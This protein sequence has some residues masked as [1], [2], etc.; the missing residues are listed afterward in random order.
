MPSSKGKYDPKITI[1]VE[2]DTKELGKLDQKIGEGFKGG[3]QKAKSFFDYVK[4]AGNAVF[5]GF[6]GKIGGMMASS[7]TRAFKKA[8]DEF[9]KLD[10]TIRKTMG[11]LSEQEIKK[12]GGIDGLK[13]IAKELSNQFGTDSSLISQN[14]FDAISLGAE[15]SEAAIKGILT[16]A[17]K[18]GKAADVESNTLVQ[19]IQG[20]TNT[21]TEFAGNAASVGDTMY[22]AMKRGAGELSDYSNGMKKVASTANVANIGMNQLAALGSSLSTTTKNVNSAFTQVERTITS[23][24]KPSGKAVKMIDQLN[25]KTGA[26]IQLGADAL[27]DK[28]LV[29]YLNEIKTAAESS[30]MKWGDVVGQIFSNVNAMKGAISLTSDSMVNTFETTFN[31]MNEAALNSGEVIEEAFG[32]MADSPKMTLDKLKQRLQN[33]FVGVIE[34]LFPLFEQLIPTIEKLLPVISN[35][36]KA[37]AGI[38]S[39]APVKFFIDALGGVSEVLARAFAPVE[40]AKGKFD[41]L[42][43]SIQKNI[44][45]VKGL[46]GIEFNKAIVEN[47]EIL[48]KKIDEVNAVAPELA[49]KMRLIAD[50]SLESSEKVQL[51]N[52]ELERFREIT[53]ATTG[54]EKGEAIKEFSRATQD[55]VFNYN[56]VI[57]KIK[58][59]EG[60]IGSLNDKQK[61]ELMEYRKKAEQIRNQF[62]VDSQKLVEMGIGKEAIEKNLK[63]IQGRMHGI[64][65]KSIFVNP[66]DKA[67]ENTYILN[68]SIE[69]LYGTIGIAEQKLKDETTDVMSGYLNLIKESNGLKEID[70]SLTSDSIVALAEINSM[71]ETQTAELAH[72]LQLKQE[73]LLLDLEILKAQQSEM[74]P[75]GV[76]YVETGEKIAETER[77]INLINTALESIPK[78]LDIGVNVEWL[79]AE[80]NLSDLK[81]S[82]TKLQESRKKFSEMPFVSQST[83]DKLDSA[84][85]ETRNKIVDASYEIAAMDVKITPEID[86][87]SLEAESE[88]VRN[89][90]DTVLQ[91]KSA[92]IG[93]TEDN[94]AMI[95]ATYQYHLDRI[96]QMSFDSE[97]EKNAQLLAL[98]QQKNEAIQS[99]FFV[100]GEQQARVDNLLTQINQI[101][102]SGAGDRQRIQLEAILQQEQAR[103]DIMKAQSAE[104]ARQLET[105]RQQKLMELIALEEERRAK[106]A[107]PIDDEEIIKIERAFEAQRKV[108]DGEIQLLDSTISGLDNTTKMQENLVNNINNSISNINTKQAEIRKQ[109]EEDRRQ[110]EKEREETEREAERERE[111]RQ[112]QLEREREEREREIER[113]REEAERKREEERRKYEEEKKQRQADAL[114]YIDRAYETDNELLAKFQDTMSEFNAIFSAEFLDEKT[115]AD[116]IKALEKNKKEIVESFVEDSLSEME[117]LQIID[118]ETAKLGFDMLREYEK[119]VM[120]LTA[121]MGEDIPKEMVETLR[122]AGVELLDQLKNKLE[123]A[124][125][126]QQ[127]E[128][129]ITYG[130]DQY[131]WLK[132]AKE[133]QK[134]LGEFEE[135]LKNFDVITDELIG[136][137]EK[138]KQDLD[139]EWLSI[140][141]ISSTAAME[142]IQDLLLDVEQAIKD[143]RDPEV[144]EQLVLLKESIENNNNLDQFQELLAAFEVI[145][146]ESGWG[147]TS[148]RSIENQIQTLVSILDYDISRRY[149][150]EDIGVQLE[151]LVNENGELHQAIMEIWDGLGDE[152]QKSYLKIED[153]YGAIQSFYETYKDEY[154]F[155]DIGDV[156]D[157]MDDLWDTVKQYQEDTNKDLKTAI[158]NTNTFIDEFYELQKAPI[159]AGKQEI[160]EQIPAIEELIKGGV[161]ATIVFKD[162]QAEFAKILDEMRLNGE[163][164]LDILKKQSEQQIE[165]IMQKQKAIVQGI[166]NIELEHELIKLRL[167]QKQIL[168]DIAEKEMELA[169]L[170][171]EYLYSTEYELLDIQKEY[172][173]S[174]LEQIELQNEVEKNQILMEVMTRKHTEEELQAAYEKMAII[175]EEFETSEE[176]LELQLEIRDV[177]K[178]QAQIVADTITTIGTAM[179]DTGKAVLKLFDVFDEGS[180]ALVEGVLDAA[181]SITGSIGQAL[182]DSVA[183][184]I[185]Q[186]I[187]AVIGIA[188]EIYKMAYEHKVKRLI[189]ETTEDLEEQKKI[190]EEINKLVDDRNAY[191]EMAKKLHLENLDTLAEEIAYRNT[192]I[193]QMKEMLGLEGAS[194]EEIIDRFNLLVKQQEILNYI[195]DSL[196]DYNENIDNWRDSDNWLREM[197]GYLE[198]M[199][200]SWEDLG[201]DIDSFGTH[202]T[203]AEREALAGILEEYLKGI[204]ADIE[205]INLLLDETATQEEDVKKEVQERWKIRQLEAELMGDITGSYDAQIAYIEE[206]LRRA[207]EFNLTTLEQLELEQQLQDLYEQRFDSILEQYEKE[208]ELYILKAKLQGATEE[209]LLDLQLEQIENMI[210]AKEIEIEQLGSTIDRELELAK[211]EEERLKLQ[212]EINGELAEQGILLDRNVQRIIQQIINT[213]ILG[214]LEAEEQ[215]IQDAIT[216]LQNQGYSN[217]EIADLLGID[218]TSIPG[219]SG[220]VPPSTAGG[221]PSLP[222]FDVSSDIGKISM[223]SVNQ[224]SELQTQTALLTEQNYLLGQMLG[225]QKV[226]KRTVRRVT[227]SNYHR[228][229]QSLDDASFS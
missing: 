15:K 207:E 59:F 40:T 177:E 106:L 227:A 58:Q 178:E 184:I 9:L 166:E 213:R 124:Y 146:G 203:T 13:D 149:K 86:T 30:G 156:L 85:E 46:E 116:L 179:L 225:I 114:D 223:E 22:L 150:D 122:E 204:G 54:E 8:G 142:G 192:T 113:E 2:V 151:S 165:L 95:E 103:L 25:E 32:K 123:S 218:V 190:H 158:K 188:A 53:T 212:Q 97:E 206:M 138:T 210:K 98:E 175:D 154:G 148:T 119:S 77:Q 27:K 72:Q 101:T 23:V 90:F 120:E 176:Y 68:E 109:A 10:T 108:I 28:T 209:E 36:G 141:G 132:Y 96:N 187:S 14:I 115:K 147:T 121:L 105:Q 69:E 1:I 159:E 49:E 79:E 201:V 94:L 137:I 82:L 162:M 37:L 80:K 45:V 47:S 215:A 93:Q 214:D 66:F 11:L 173:K 29:E 229:V 197:N 189:E 35:L 181:Q 160:H 110:Q 71:T 170:K 193:E 191:L 51:M 221:L 168:A 73:A 75:G 60:K 216:I 226:E 18:L 208:M 131:N 63:N 126:E 88:Q 104:Q 130:G 129:L 83:L 74:E 39:S 180:K 19:A 127:T 172:V 111:E 224:L 57:D 48:K 81:D 128:L 64:V 20:I 61:V 65:A 194:N 12:L 26:N 7:L 21:Y 161:E 211:L 182:G 41:E 164:E 171:A 163:S 118:A 157:S 152:F 76:E 42:Y 87:Q 52:A 6:F 5:G 84:I 198:E 43:T 220:T 102:E 222:D 44:E 24:L 125:K 139:I 92:D 135:Q 185:F 199:G 4:K 78:V 38:L 112:R 167:E 144:K 16:T 34:N 186:A 174:K 145:K 153:S 89:Y 91:A 183:G 31:E 169:L 205:D 100:E 140:S 62:K 196:T 133:Q 67:T 200:V 117:G 136:T 228:A 17:E 219:G 155:E 56:D 107:E 217:Q 134:R 33:T 99:M 195:N 70:R 3:K 55:L 143:A 202:L 50:S